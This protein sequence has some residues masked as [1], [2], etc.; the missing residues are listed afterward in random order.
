MVCL[1]KGLFLV[2]AGLPM[3]LLLKVNQSLKVPLPGG[4]EG[5]E[6]LLLLY[7]EVRVTRREPHRF[8]IPVRFFI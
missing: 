8:R 2:I 7:N 5:V 4:G 3:A 1:S 6:Q